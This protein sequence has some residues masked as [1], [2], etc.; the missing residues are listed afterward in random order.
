[1]M[2][3]V[4]PLRGSNRSQT[5]SARGN[6]RKNVAPRASSFTSRLARIRRSTRSSDLM[7]ISLSVMGGIG[8]FLTL[9]FGNAYHTLARDIWEGGIRNQHFTTLLDQLFCGC[10]K[11]K[12]GAGGKPAPSP[13][14]EST[15]RINVA[16]LSCNSRAAM[17]RS[18]AEH[19]VNFV[20]FCG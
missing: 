17:M 14:G 8:S 18:T 6:A 13:N 15:R 19:F 1:M 9:I 7:M 20:P 11:K 2:A 3:I 4:V 16:K 12:T 5:L 10:L